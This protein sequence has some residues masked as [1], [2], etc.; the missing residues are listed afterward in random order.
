MESIQES[1]CPRTSLHFAIWSRGKKPADQAR[2]GSG[3]PGLISS[4]IHYHCL[5]FEDK[6]TEA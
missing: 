6:E 4:M 1:I 5:Y 3:P 2:I